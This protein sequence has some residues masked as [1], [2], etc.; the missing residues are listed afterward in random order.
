VVISQEIGEKRGIAYCL[1]GFAKIAARYG[2][3]RQ[4]ACLLG[5]AEALRQ[6]IGAPLSQVECA[7]LDQDVI[8]TRERLGEKILSWRGPQAVQ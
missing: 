2:N 5:A 3:G 7:E 8:V 1:E 6:T 4:A